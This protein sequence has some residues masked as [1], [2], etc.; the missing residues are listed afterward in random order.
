MLR[1]AYRCRDCLE[2]VFHETAN[3]IYGWDCLLCRDGAAWGKLEVLGRVERARLVV[4]H[5]APACDG[6]CTHARGNKCDCQCGGANHGSGRT[7]TWTTDGGPCVP[8]DLDR[9]TALERARELRAERARAHERL[10]R[11]DA[12]RL[13]KAAGEYLSGPDFTDWLEGDRAH[14]ALHH[15]LALRTHGGRLR[16][17]ATVAVAPAGAAQ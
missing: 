6:R 14:R 2:V 12:V 9:T 7:V 5:A 11:Y 10:R 3:G 13:R 4:D 17:L 1:Y 8:A 16:A 15:A